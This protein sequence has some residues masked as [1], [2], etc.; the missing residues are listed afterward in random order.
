MAEV[1]RSRK[2]ERRIDRSAGPTSEAQKACRAHAQ[3][4]GEDQVQFLTLADFV[5]RRHPIQS[6]GSNRSSSSNE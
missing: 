6:R 2:G 3:R 4:I 5:R 1:R